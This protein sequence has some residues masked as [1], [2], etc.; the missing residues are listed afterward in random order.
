MGANCGKEDVVS[1][2][3]VEWNTMNIKRLSSDPKEGSPKK[4]SHYTRRS[5]ETNKCFSESDAPPSASPV[6][7]FEILSVGK[8]DEN[9]SREKTTAPFTSLR[10]FTASGDLAQ[11]A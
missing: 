3:R 9:M 8:D 11:N 5:S 4:P 6:K 7:A 10:D 1:P 2:T